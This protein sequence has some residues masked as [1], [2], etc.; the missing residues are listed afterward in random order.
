MI[1][2]LLRIE[3]I[4]FLATVLNASYIPLQDFVDLRN[5]HP[6]DLGFTFKPSPCK[7]KQSESKHPFEPFQSYLDLPE[8][9]HER[10]ILP[11]LTASDKNILR[12]ARKNLHNLPFQLYPLQITKL[13]QQ[14]R[15]LHGRKECQIF[16]RPIRFRE[17]EASQEQNVFD[18]ERK[19][20]SFE[21]TYKS[22]MFTFHVRQGSMCIK[23]YTEYAREDEFYA[24]D[25]VSA[26]QR[27]LIRVH[28]I[29]VKPNAPWKILSGFFHPRKPIEE[30]R[31]AFMEGI[32]C[33]FVLR[34]IQN[35]KLVSSSDLVSSLKLEAT[36]GVEDYIWGRI[37]YK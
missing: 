27:M 13:V 11:F 24:L 33:V 29:V 32:E 35:G 20:Y 31:E 34:K 10:R 22:F 2:S 28:D 1:Q 23:I 6:Q 7:Q 18:T 36:R 37:C 17:L 26:D 4:L 25:F 14:A 3:A 30:V 16:V 5:A 21:F 15:H 8:N 9:F 12:L 19:Y